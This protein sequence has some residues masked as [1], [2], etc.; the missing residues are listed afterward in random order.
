MLSVAIKQYCRLGQQVLQQKEMCITCD[1][2]VFCRKR[3]EVSYAHFSFDFS[4]SSFSSSDCL[5]GGKRLFFAK[6]A[7]VIFHS[8]QF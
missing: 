4:S 2:S 6:N 1:K 7:H 3:R 8:V 5:D